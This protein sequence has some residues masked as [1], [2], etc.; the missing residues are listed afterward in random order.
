VAGR[1]RRRPAAVPARVPGAPEGKR[2]ARKTRRGSGRGEAGERRKAA[3]A[4][5]HCGKRRPLSRMSLTTA[6]VALCQLSAILLLVVGPISSSH[7]THTSSSTQALASNTWVKPSHPHTSAYR[8]STL[9]YS[10]VG[11][12]F[13]THTK[14]VIFC[15]PL[16]GIVLIS[17]PCLSYS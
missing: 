1:E 7:V 9:P 8:N 5:T 10:T 4:L 12:C 13:R 11:Y 17:V 6:D 2:G 3:V 15:T 14:I 16:L